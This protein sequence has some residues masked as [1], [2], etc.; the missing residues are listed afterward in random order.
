MISID[1]SGIYAVVAFIILIGAFENVKGQE[2]ELKLVNVVFRHGDR[3]PDDNGYELYPNDPFLKYDFYPTGLGEL[4]NKGKAREYQL[5]QFLR[6]KYDKFLGKLYTPNI[7]EARSS[8]YRRTKASLQLV[9]AGL[10]PPVLIQKWNTIINWQPIPTDYTPRLYDNLLLPDEC[11]RYLN[12][13]DKVLEIPEIKEELAGFD[14]MNAKLTEL[15]GK[16]ISTPWDMYY[17]YHTFMAESSMNLHLPE[18]AYSV[19]PYGRLYD[20]IIFAYKVANYNKLQKKIYG[21]AILR[22]FIENMKVHVNDT[23]KP[24]K[25]IYL[26]SGHETNIASLLSTL[27]IYQPHVPEYSSAVLVE[28]LYK[29][30]TYYV[31][32]LYYVGIPSQIKEM[33]LPGCEVLCP[34]EKFLQITTDVIPTDQDLICDKTETNA[35]ANQ[36]PDPNANRNLYNVINSYITN[37]I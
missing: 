11:P 22:K 24:G 35:Y 15:T 30:N 27:D 2:A 28:L 32:I 19:F 14:D 33:K 3:T 5:G 17:L 36:K 8:D 25:R 6:T 12:E 34:L 29:E 7:L 26:Y 37:R 21:G 10:Y 23:L 20:G 1:N 18:W 4:T 16:N 9:L 31:K 13:Y